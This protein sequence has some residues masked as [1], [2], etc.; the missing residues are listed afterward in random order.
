MPVAFVIRENNMGGASFLRILPRGLPWQGTS[1]PRHTPALGHV[2][3][4]PCVKSPGQGRGL[5]QCFPGV[6]FIPPT[7]SEAY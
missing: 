3:L 7:S 6:P 2:A 4:S 1:T 5:S